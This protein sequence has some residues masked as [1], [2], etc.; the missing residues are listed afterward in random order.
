MYNILSK[1]YRFYTIKKREKLDILI[2]DKNNKKNTSSACV[3]FIVFVEQL[4][5]QQ[6][7]NPNQCQ[8]NCQYFNNICSFNSMRKIGSQLCTRNYSS[9]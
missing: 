7:P 2:N 9:C 3:F 5:L 6:N 4:V 8:T 1:N